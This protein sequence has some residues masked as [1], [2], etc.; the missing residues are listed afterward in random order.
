MEEEVC[1]KIAKGIQQWKSRKLF[2][3]SPTKNKIIYITLY[4]SILPD[5]KVGFLLQQI[6]H[7]I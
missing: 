4:Q 5:L 1:I 7:S 2:S 3:F 6:N